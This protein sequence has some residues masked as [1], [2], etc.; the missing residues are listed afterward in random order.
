M[1]TATVTKEIAQLENQLAQLR[2]PGRPSREV[3]DIRSRLEELKKNGAGKVAKKAKAEVDEI[4]DADAPEKKGGRKP[5]EKK[6]EEKE[7]E[8]ILRPLQMGHLE[9]EIIGTSDLIQNK[10]SAKALQEMAD[11]G[12]GRVSK[13]R[14][15]APRKPKDE[16][17]AAR[18]ID[19]KN[20][21]CM[22][23]VQFKKAM[24]TV[25]SE[26]GIKGITG[27]TI[28]RW[29][30]VRSMVSESKDR[31]L[32]PIHHSEKQPHMREDVVRV[33]PFGNRVAMLRYR[34]SYSQWRVRISIEFNNS[35]I[36]AE[37]IINLLNWAG[38]GVGVAEWRPEKAGEFGRF[39]V[40]EVIN[41]PKNKGRK[42]S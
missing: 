4:I 28:K 40:G 31:D 42:A 10:F 16:F 34:P 2:K 20:R 5:R 9:L 11:K 41:A 18:Y 29:V 23:A 15:R 32:V 30:F 8:L 37:H 33:G 7:E 24:T 3:L 12:E 25:A 1:L 38:F 35:S 19:Y 36:S 6:V 14:A 26:K 21:D 39:E 27:S 17:N 13:D 22:P